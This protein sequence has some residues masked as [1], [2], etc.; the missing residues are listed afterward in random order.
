MHSVV[1]G[2][3]RNDD[4][5]VAE[6]VYVLLKAK[7]VYQKVKLFIFR[8]L[9]PAF[10]VAVDGFSSQRENGL[11]L[12]IAGLGDGTAC[13]ISL[14][15]EDAGLFPELLL[16]CRELVLV[17]I[18]SVPELLVVDVGPFVPFLGLFLYGGYL[19]PFLL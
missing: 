6:V 16:C 4:L 13:R 9:L 7:G 14:G 18:F 8:N 19:L 12:G 5:V 11:R 3:R 1:V 17:V 10:L 2:I 15:D